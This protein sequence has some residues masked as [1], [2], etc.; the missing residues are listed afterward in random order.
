MRG[1]PLIW[2]AALW[3]L[4]GCLGET[5]TGPS[6]GTDA[7]NVIEA[8][9]LYN[10][11]VVVRGPRGYCLD[12][13][14]IRRRASNQLVLMAS[15]ESLRGELGFSVPPAL[16]VVNVSARRAG[17]E[18][19]SAAAI[20]ASMAPKTPLEVVDGD[21]I[22]LVHLDAGGER[23]L[24]GGDPRYWRAGMALNGHFVSLAVYGPKGSPV[25]GVTGKRL[26]IDI[27]ESL[28]DASP[29]KRAAQPQTAPTPQTSVTRKKSGLLG[30]LFPK[31]G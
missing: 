14:S 19:P 22:A 9:P 4:A 17:R 23:A 12:A 20:V 15:C 30:G 13:D 16:I 21:G 31:S 25:A 26:I 18:Q 8:L 3:P 29:V 10:G 27:A 1:I 5:G 28:R 6:P 11:E 7:P 2:L 24:P